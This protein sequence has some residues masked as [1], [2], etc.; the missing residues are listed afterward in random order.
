MGS[1]IQIAT[2]GFDDN[3]SYIVFDPE[4]RDTALVDPCGDTNRILSELG[5]LD[6]PEPRYILLTH[7]HGDHIS[8]VA[9][10]KSFFDAPVAAHPQCSFRHDIDLDDR[11]RLPFAKTYIECL[12]SPGHTRDSV[13]YRLG[14]DE[15]I[16]TGDTL[17]IDCCGY[18]DAE[19]MF[20][21]MRG[22]VFP[23]PGSNE[24][25]PGHNY[26]HVP[27]EPLE[28]QKTRNPYLSTDDFGEFRR[29]L[30]DL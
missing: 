3:Y 12:H 24:V 2:G 19:T 4:S 27:H 29:R 30:K 5:K 23:L 14:T 26:G 7:G 18:C 9:A 21:T 11:K 8:G 1:I 15:A 25:Y 6:A 22:V 16:F 17:F 13:I 20:R 10:V 28:K